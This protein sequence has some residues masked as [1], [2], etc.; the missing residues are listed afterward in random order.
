MKSK[1]EKLS[2]TIAAASPKAASALVR[3][4]MHYRPE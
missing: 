1:N 2:L 3:P 4:G